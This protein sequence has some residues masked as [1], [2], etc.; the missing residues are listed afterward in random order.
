MYRLRIIFFLICFHSGNFLSAQWFVGVKFMGVTFHTDKNQNAGLYKVAFGK[1]K[2]VS[3]N[4]GVALT[5]EYY[6]YQHTV[7]VKYDQALFRDCAGKF[8]GSS[9]LTIRYTLDMQRLGEGSVGMGPFF[10]YRKNWNALPGYIDDGYFRSSSNG[11]WQRKFVWYGGEFEYDHRI[12]NDLDFSLNLFPG[13]PV[14]YA[15]TPGVRMRVR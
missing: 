4:F 9:L 13:Y 6:F 11:K 1:N 15:L 7:S 10:F 12:K 3:L 8:A 2:R 14:V 5:A